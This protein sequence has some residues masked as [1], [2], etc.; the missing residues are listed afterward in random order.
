M[1]EVDY[2]SF[3]SLSTVP[4]TTTTAAPTTI[5]RTAT[6]EVKKTEIYNEIRR[7]IY[8]KWA[9]E[10]GDPVFNEVRI[11]PY[12]KNGAKYALRIDE[13]VFVCKS[14]IQAYTFITDYPDS[15]A[16]ATHILEENNNA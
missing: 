9:E 2:S 11:I 14:I 1:S 8:G 5:T 4:T 13:Y 15:I 10:K 7:D 6:P 16:D 12:T 3:V